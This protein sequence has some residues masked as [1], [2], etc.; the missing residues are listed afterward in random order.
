[1]ELDKEI[2]EKLWS[3]HLLWVCGAGCQEEK[4]NEHKGKSKS[5]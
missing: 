3:Q 5:N 2:H 1:V 4:L